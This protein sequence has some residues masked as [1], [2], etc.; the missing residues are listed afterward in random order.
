M[1]KMRMAMMLPGAVSL[2]AYEGGALA[3]LLVGLGQ[4]DGAVVVD[5]IA[6]ASAGSITALLTTRCLLRGADP[7]NLMAEGW[8]T[9]PSRRTLR[10]RDAESPLSMDALREQ[11]S[12]LL[13]A[14]GAPDGPP[15][16]TEPV[17]LSM[18]LAS[19]GG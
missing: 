16:Q 14:D 15:I 19:L 7:V 2:G 18:A 17:H 3:A 6:S 12:S 10:E 8:G 9:L 5:S 1:P 4:L 13:S 11:A